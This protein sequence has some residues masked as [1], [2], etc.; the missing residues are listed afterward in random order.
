[1]SI[2]ILICSLHKFWESQRTIYQNTITKISSISEGV[3]SRDETRN[4]LSVQGV[5]FLM[6]MCRFVH[7]C[8]SIKESNR[9]HQKTAYT[10]H[11]NLRLNFHKCSWMTCPKNA[12]QEHHTMLFTTPPLIVCQHTSPT[13]FSM[14]LSLYF[15]KT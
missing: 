2:T 13:L 8:T 10:P 15:C 11:Q 1:M 9:Y 12:Y 5:H 4:A 7:L 14:Y 6:W 3:M